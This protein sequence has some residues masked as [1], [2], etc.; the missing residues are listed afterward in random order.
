MGRQDKLART[1]QAAAELLDAAQ[2]L[3]GDRVRLA[4]AHTVHLECR[5]CIKHVDFCAAS[6][7]PRKRP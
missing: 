1:E 2:G 4:A 7:K 6:C 5:L 3:Q